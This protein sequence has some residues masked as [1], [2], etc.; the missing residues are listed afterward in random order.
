[1]FDA[2]FETF[3][4]KAIPTLCSQE[5]VDGVI[6][7]A[8]STDS[9]FKFRIFNLDGSEAAQCGNG[10]RCFALFL[11]ELGI[12]KETYFI[13][14]IAGIKKAQ[15]RQAQVVSVEMGSFAFPTKH[16]LEGHEIYCLN[17]GVPHGIVFTEDLENAPLLSLGKT[18]RTLLD[19]NVNF[20]RPGKEGLTIRTFER[21][22]EGE[23]LACGTGAIASALCLAFLQHL[24]SPLSVTFRSKEQV[25]IA[26][27]RKNEG[28]TEVIMQGSAKKLFQ[29]MV[30]L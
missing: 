21:G 15:I 28:F 27:Q 26:F 4:F 3:D 22:V 19:C 30:A 17:T 9:V 14:T 1:M 24:P 5:S 10:L 12:E 6:L 8:P 13:E 23:T 7:L 29:G 16:P 2:R 18:I 25:T 20:V 11:K